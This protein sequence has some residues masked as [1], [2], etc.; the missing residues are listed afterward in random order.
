[1][2]RKGR[3]VTVG[4][5][6]LNFPIAAIRIERRE[7]IRVAQKFRTLFHPRDQVRITYR[8]GVQLAVIDAKAKR[9]IIIWGK[10]D[11]RY[12]VGIRR[13]DQVLRDKFVYLFFLKLAGGWAGPVRCGVNRLR[14]L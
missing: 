5:I 13:L 9:S 7:D 2:G 4:V 6:N 3:F 14:V 10:V 12:P 1:M 8:Y 11:R